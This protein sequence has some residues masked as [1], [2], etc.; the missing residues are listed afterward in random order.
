MSSI[1]P[2]PAPS[3]CNAVLE[4][5]NRRWPPPQTNEREDKPV[6]TEMIGDMLGMMKDQPL[7]LFWAILLATFILEDVATVTA[8]LLAADGMIHPAAALSA[9]YIG[10]IIGDLGL[11]GL[12]YGAG[13]W[14][15]LRE[16]IGM[17]RLNKGRDWLGQRLILTLLGARFVPGL[18]L[19]TYTTSGFVR[20]PLTRFAMIIVTACLLWTTSFF[21]LVLTFGQLAAQIFGEWSWVPGLL[22]VAAAIFLPRLIAKRFGANGTNTDGIT[23]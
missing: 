21:F 6:S 7:L 17:D 19:P 20:V 23:S 5:N 18:R 14:Q 3:A 13:Q 12:G 16:R 22:L 15:W 1:R 11:Y 8:G 10:I 4:H 9:L 2:S